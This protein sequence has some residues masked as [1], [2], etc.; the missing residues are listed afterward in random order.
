MIDQYSSEEVKN[1]IYDVKID[2]SPIMRWRSQD[3][4]PYN[5]IRKI[6]SYLM[7]YNTGFNSEDKATD[8]YSVAIFNLTL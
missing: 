3:D 8:S 4:S 7:L 2:N 1:K 6:F 5:D